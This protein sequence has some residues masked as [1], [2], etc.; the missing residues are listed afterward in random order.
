MASEIIQSAVSDVNIENIK[1]M[2]GIMAISAPNIIRSLERFKY[3]K[4][5]YDIYET[6]VSQNLKP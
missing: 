4:I 6:S 3:L 1:K 5:Q 2:S